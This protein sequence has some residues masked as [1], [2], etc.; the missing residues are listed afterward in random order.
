MISR[1]PATSEISQTEMQTW[2][3]KNLQST[4]MGSAEISS[5][6]YWGSALWEHSKLPSRMKT[7]QWYD[8]CWACSTETQERSKVHLHKWVAR[9]SIFS[10]TEP[11]LMF[12]TTTQ[13]TNVTPCWLLQYSLL[14]LPVSST[15]QRKAGSDLCTVIQSWAISPYFLAQ[16]CVERTICLHMF[17]PIILS[18]YSCSC[19]VYVHCSQLLPFR[20]CSY[21]PSHSSGSENLNLA[22]VMHLLAWQY[23][24]AIITVGMVIW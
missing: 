1:L 13:Q 20:C 21:F 6:S 23:D 19:P 10:V 24:I 2:S 22:P 4:S 12:A 15:L 11:L 17:C 8:P 7:R 9:V 5:G 18:F 14:P 3:I 16:K